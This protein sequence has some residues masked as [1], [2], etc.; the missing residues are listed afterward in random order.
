MLMYSHVRQFRDT[1]LEVLSCGRYISHEP[2]VSINMCSSSRNINTHSK[3]S[4]LWP[5]Q[6]QRSCHVFTSDSLRKQSFQTRLHFRQM[7]T[8]GECRPFHC[9]CTIHLTLFCFGILLNYITL[10]VCSL[11]PFFLKQHGCSVRWNLVLHIHVFRSV[12]VLG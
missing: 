1:T 9:H 11:S 7:R 4:P 3:V 6:K 8:V 12:W 5:L 2:S 10:C